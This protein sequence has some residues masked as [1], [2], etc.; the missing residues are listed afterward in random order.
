MF[1]S[2]L[3][4]QIELAYS[5][6][7]LFQVEFGGQLISADEADEVRC[8]FDWRRPPWMSDPGR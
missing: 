4:S 3:A 8:C 5:V 2:A 1:G 6:F 7:P